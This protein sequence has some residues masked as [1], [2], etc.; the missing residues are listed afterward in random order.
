MTGLRNKILGSWE[1]TSFSS[2]D[3]DTGVVRYPL[4]LEPRGL[5]MYTDDGYMSAQLTGPG[6]TGYIAYGGRFHVDEQSAI[7]HHDVTISML[8]ELLTQPQYR[9]ASV[10][11][12]RLTLSATATDSDETTTHNSLVWTRATPTVAGSQ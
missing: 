12:D 7:L 2:R 9:H 4:G 5:I 1:L 10:D 6:L 8:P 11:G 3:V